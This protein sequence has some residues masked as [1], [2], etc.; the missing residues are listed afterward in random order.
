M[1][2][3]IKLFEEYSESSH[4]Q[5]MSTIRRKGG[6]RTILISVTE[7]FAG[8]LEQLHN[9]I[10]GCSMGNYAIGYVRD[11]NEDIV[12]IGL[13]KTNN[14]YRSRN[15][16]IYDI[17]GEEVDYGEMGLEKISEIRI[18]NKNDKEELIDSIDILLEKVKIK[19]YAENTEDGKYI[20]VYCVG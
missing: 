20:K 12:V 19:L 10:D 15:F 18:E 3:H 11:L 1:K 6:S 14:I 5:L 13:F 7:S 8:T 16:D 4:K 2:K 17:Y 9:L